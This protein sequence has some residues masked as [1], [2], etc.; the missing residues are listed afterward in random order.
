MAEKLDTLYQN[1]I[2]QRFSNE[3]LQLVDYSNEFLDYADDTIDILHFL[4]K[5]TIDK[6]IEC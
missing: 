2:E 6:R 1:D 4:Y 3:V 5:L